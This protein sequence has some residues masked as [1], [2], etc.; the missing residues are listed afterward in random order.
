MGE[1]VGRGGG[2]RGSGEEKGVERV[3]WRGRIRGEEGTDFSSSAGEA[4][5]L[6]V[7]CEGG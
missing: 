7:T 5:S 4:P 6:S 3:R 1:R 2:A